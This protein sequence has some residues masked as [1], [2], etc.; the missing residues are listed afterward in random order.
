VNNGGGTK[1]FTY[2]AAVAIGICSGPVGGINRF[3]ENKN[4]Y[5]GLADTT[6]TTAFSIFA[7]TNPQTPWG[8]LSS[9]NPAQAIGYSGLAYVACPVVTL[10]SSA[11]LSNYSFELAGR[12]MS[13]LLV[14]P[15]G[16][17]Y[18]SMMGPNSWS[19][20]NSTWDGA[21]YNG[22]AVL[23]VNLTGLQSIGLYLQNQQGQVVLTFTGPSTLTVMDDNGNQ[24]VVTS[25]E[26]FVSDG[27]MYIAGSSSFS[28]TNIQIQTGYSPAISQFSSTVGTGVLDEDPGYIINDLLA[29]VP[30]PATS[31][32][33]L[34]NY[35]SYCRAAN[36]LISPAYTEQEAANSILQDI[37][38]AT[39]SEF[40]WSQGQLTLVPYADA[41]YTGNGV[42]FTPNMTPWYDLNDDDFIVSTA[43]TPG[44]QVQDITGQTSGGLSD[45]SAV[46]DPITCSRSL[47]ADAYN[48][49]Q[50]EYADRSLDYNIAIA[51]AQDQ[52]DI[53]LRGL[54][55]MSPS[56]MHFICDRDIANAVAQIILQRI[57]YIRNTYTFNLSWR[58]CLLEPMDLVTIN[59]ALMGINAAPV[60]IKSIEEA[61]DGLLTVT[62]EECPI[63]VY[64]HA[65][66]QHQNPLGYI[67]NYQVAPGWVNAPVI[68]E[69]PAALTASSGLEVWLG[70]SGGSNWGGADVWVSQDGVSYQKMGTV[71]GS[72]RQGT[73]IGALPSSADPDTTDGLNVS[74]SESQGVLLSGTQAD[75]DTF[76]TL[77]YVDG[78]L[79][80]YQ[81]ATLLATNQYKLTYLRRGAYGSSIAPHLA[82]SPFLR[83]D[84]SVFKYAY[85]ADMVG[86]RLY[87]KFAS[88][89]IYGG[90]TTGISQ[91]PVYQ[92]IVTGAAL[93]LAPANITGI[94]DYYAGTV[95]HI[96]W[97]PITDF[98]PF[99]YEVRFGA[100]YATAMILGTTA[101]T[102]FVAQSNG[103]YWVTAKTTESGISAYSS[104]PTEII[105]GGSVIVKN[106]VQ[107]YDELATGWSG[108][109]SGGAEI[110]V[111]NRVWLKS[112]DVLT[113]SAGVLLTDSTGTDIIANN[114]GV[115]D[116]S[117]I[118]T[119]PSS[120]IVDIGAVTLCQLSVQY[121]ALSDMPSD[122][123]DSVQDFDGVTDFDGNYAGYSNVQIQVQVYNGT[124]W[125][126]W[127]PFVAGP[128]IG[129]KFNFQAVLTS[130]SPTITAVLSAFSFTVDMPDRVDTGTGVGVL[131][132]GTAVAFATSFDSVPNVQITVLGAQPGDVITF[133]VA[134]TES[135]FTVKITNGGSGV[136][137]SINW[138][139]QG[140]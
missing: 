112:T 44:D 20:P 2:Q 75:A 70:L 55:T 136:A 123:V 139:A 140:Y 51:D 45:T 19:D 42:T 50:I 17:T 117:G 22:T 85:P 1:S 69:A 80:S 113:D 111:A 76:N 36:L 59:D 122:L 77:C 132:G 73:L 8:F 98:R 104:T 100:S 38:Q 9:T 86:S 137:R 82:N 34:S 92:Y 4:R 26:A 12:G 24:S 94:Y 93:K 35:S 60:R 99:V 116:P 21:K 56:T 46:D 115:V 30:F 91:V 102:D 49:I 84:Q 29:Q 72:A 67:P 103:T 121:T 11:T 126:P 128:Y 41:S 120:H 32:G 66:Y 6:A 78:E 130:N 25:G 101:T 133:P 109:L 110:D 79:L 63:G 14:T 7:G 16:Y 131:S 18:T 124:S 118:Y 87:F 83:L 68:F 48:H 89:N 65:I 90:G 125:G 96:T 58:Y 43:N 74:L 138:L 27:V 39:N 54:R 88:F 64:N 53:E 3:W 61:A 13:G 105:I 15:A 71:R 119:I 62:A 134:T 33:N 135:G 114:P 81:T 129:Q 31:I 57:L 28:I 52:A 40:V 95:A 107:T 47:T 106:V 37:A 108:A 10:D 97:N 127:M 23:Q 5:N